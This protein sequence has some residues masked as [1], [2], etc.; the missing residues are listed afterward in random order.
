MPKAPDK[1][2]PTF[3]GAVSDLPEEEEIRVGVPIGRAPE[4]A[5][6]AR[7]GSSRAVDLSGRTRALILPGRGKVGKTTLIRWMAERAVA[8]G[9][10][11]LLADL[12]RTNATLASYFEGVAR[13]EYGD[14]ATTT[15]WLE[16][17]FQHIGR[18][19]Q[20]ALVD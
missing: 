1:T 11:V 6:E 8:A 12:D 18:A 5:G 16:R 2:G 20:N 17:L 15:A 14:D 19:K 13:P 3:R 4:G 10:D 7:G 9:R